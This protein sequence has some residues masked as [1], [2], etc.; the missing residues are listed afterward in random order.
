MA[1]MALYAQGWTGGHLDTQ[2]M[3]D[4]ARI[5]APAWWQL[6]CAAVPSASH[7]RFG[8]ETTTQAPFSALWVGG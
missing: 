5:H 1:S 7:A 8:H 4:R 3:L 6:L 2:G